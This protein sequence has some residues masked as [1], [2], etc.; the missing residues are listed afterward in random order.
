MPCISG[1]S[2][3]H[4]V[5]TNL[6]NKKNKNRKC[7]IS[8]QYTPQNKVCLTTT[9]LRIELGDNWIILDFYK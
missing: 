5:N 4:G 2:A 7:L 1:C 9:V 3:L 6:K 8:I